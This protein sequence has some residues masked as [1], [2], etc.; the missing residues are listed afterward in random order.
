M[1][2]QYINRITLLTSRDYHSVLVLILLSSPVFHSVLV[3]RRLRRQKLQYNTF[4]NRWMFITK[5]LWKD[6]IGSEVTFSLDRSTISWNGNINSLYHSIMRGN[7]LENYFHH[8][9]M[10]E[11][12]HPFLFLLIT[13]E[14]ITRKRICLHEYLTDLRN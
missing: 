1:E 7:E 4:L 8:P 5:S 10:E 12:H 2:S 14:E 6:W 13:M 3:L 11:N 9:S